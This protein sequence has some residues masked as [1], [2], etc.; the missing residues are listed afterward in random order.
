MEQLDCIGGG[1][2]S[3]YVELHESGGCVK[4]YFGFDGYKALNL[5]TQYAKCEQLAMTTTTCQ[6]NH[7]WSSIFEYTY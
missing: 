5:E 3:Y 4:S 2:D 1:A 6:L 7:A